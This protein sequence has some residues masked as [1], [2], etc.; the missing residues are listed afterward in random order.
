MELRLSGKY[1]VIP[2]KKSPLFEI[3]LVLVCLDHVA[4]TIKY[5]NHSVMRAAEKLS[6][7]DCVIDC[8]W[9]AI[10]QP[11]EWQCIGN[12]IDAAMIGARSDFVNVHRDIVDNYG[13]MTDFRAY[14]EKGRSTN[15]E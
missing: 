2:A 9:L 5:P 8:V 12:Q 13:S 14:Q 1:D 3:S 4:P 6:V 10:P 15:N 11:A 7:V